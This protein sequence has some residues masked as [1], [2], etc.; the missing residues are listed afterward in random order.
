M[1]RLTDK[2]ASYS[3]WKGIS[4]DEPSYTLT[5]TRTGSKTPYTNM[6]NGNFTQDGTNVPTVVEGPMPGQNAY[7]FTLNSNTTPLTTSRLYYGSPTS[8]QVGGLDDIRRAYY[9]ASP[10]DRVYGIWMRMPNASSNPNGLINA[11]RILGGSNG[12]TV[13]TGVAMGKLPDGSPGISIS[14]QELGASAGLLQNISQYGN[15]TDGFKNLEHGKWYFIAWRKRMTISTTFPTVNSTVNG[16]LTYDVY[17]NG[18]L[19]R[20]ATVTTFPYYSANMIEFGRTSAAFGLNSFDMGCWFASEWS[21]IG[22]QGL[23][24]IY[25]YGS[26]TNRDFQGN[27]DIRY[28]VEGSGWFGSTNERVYRNGSWQDVFASRWD[29]TQ[30]LPI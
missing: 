2:V 13:M 17:I 1:S 22:E 7:R 8:G 20:S 9:D 3:H 12:Q 23:K 16:T 14:S 10:F 26:G 18:S 11:H 24:D 15:S 6:S 21:D 19:T 4:F 29:G 25:K 5:P 30:W 27:A 28:Y